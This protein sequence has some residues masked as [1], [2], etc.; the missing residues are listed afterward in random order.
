[1][2]KKRQKANGEGSVYQRESDGRYAGSIRVGRD[3]TG[4]VIRKTVYGKT[5]KEAANKLAD[6]VS[7]HSLGNYVEPS[8]T[9]L[10]MWLDRWMEVYMSGARP[11][12]ID[13]YQSHIEKQIKPR[14]GDLALK[15]LSSSNIQQFI[16]WCLKQGNANT[17]GGLSTKSVRNII[18]VLSSALAQAVREGLLASN[19]VSLVK[20]P[21]LQRKPI[22]ALSPADLRQLLDAARDDKYHAAYALAV[23]CGLRRGELLGLRWKDI[24]RKERLLKVEQ[25]VVRVNAPGG[26]HKTELIFQPPKTEAGRRI[27]PIPDYAYEA[28]QRYRKQQAVF[29]VLIFHRGDGR[30]LDPASFVRDR[31][32]PLLARAGL[33]DAT[34]HALRHAYAT[35][36]ISEIGEDPKTVQ[37]LLGHSEVGTTLNIYAKAVGDAKKRAASRLNGLLQK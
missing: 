2:T 11:K 7:K 30:P 27:I 8:K 10:S 4:K 15:R 25:E 37:A 14:L 3:A 17:G 1:M 26:P 31:Y 21:K 34:L 6:I 32:K 13:S 16:N 18:V 33:P 36:L 9:T 19:P 20:R 23:F 35:N 22:A 28:L 5:K 24:D 29:E 12:T